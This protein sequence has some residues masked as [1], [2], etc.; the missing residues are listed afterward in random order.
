[1]QLTRA[2][3][4]AT[5]WRMRS[6]DDSRWSAWRVLGIYSSL[7]SN[8]TWMILLR[9][10]TCHWACCTYASHGIWYSA[11]ALFLCCFL[12]CGDALWW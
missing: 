4:V 8:A 6:I 12:M 7:L 9:W 5:V 11:L 1:M 2:R 3:R 10:Y